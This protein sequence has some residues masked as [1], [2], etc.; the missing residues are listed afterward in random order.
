MV[1]KAKRFMVLFLAVVMILQIS[2]MALNSAVEFSDVNSSS[3]YKSQ[4][5]MLITYTPGIINGR[6]D[7]DG[8][9]KPEFDPN[10]TL[11]R[12]EFVK[13][14]A[15][16]G[17]EMI[18]AQSGNTRPY[19]PTPVG[20]EHWAAPYWR[21][22]NKYNV[23]AG[24]YNADT[25][26]FSQYYESMETYIT[27]Y[28]MAVMIV[29]FLIN[30]MWE[31]N[32][33][34]NME[35]AK[36]T[37]TDYSS[38]PSKYQNA[39]V[40]AYG[41]GIITGFE[42]GSFQG[43]DILTRAQCVAVIYRILWSGNRPKANFVNEEIQ[44]ISNKPAGYTP[45]ATR[46]VQNGWISSG[47]SVKSDQLYLELMGS[48]TKKYFTSSADAAAYMQTVTVPV[49]QINNKGVKY[50]AKISITVNKA[51]AQDII[52][53]FT[54]IYN[55]PEK[56]PI[57]SAGGARFTDTL[58]H[59]WGCAIDINPY[60]NAECR[61]YYDNSGTVT[62]VKQTCGYGWWPE[63]TNWTAFAGSM[64][65]ASPYSIGANSSV[66]QA[67]KDYGW[68]WAGNGYSKYNGSQKFDFMHFSILPN[69][70]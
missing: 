53:I 61:A 6:P 24:L 7:S 48:T 57:Q 60:Q 42:D 4:L 43:S 22:L 50:S 41:K 65:A 46:Y 11:K 31:S 3:W 23:F 17:D 59:S 18:M 13:M 30:I 27:R 26:E 8:D 2:S 1:K 36:T 10:G 47:G 70:G 19:D 28:E 62:S 69:G 54:E 49:W 58:R 29:N 20:N 5:D 52:G 63:G 37:I 25:N 21:I 35:K 56:F 16:A 64:S 44:T 32:V 68:G 34:V 9:G 14:L 33:S 38:I 39:V 51:V 12:G 45:A 15:V 67:F 40:Q 66:V 55:S